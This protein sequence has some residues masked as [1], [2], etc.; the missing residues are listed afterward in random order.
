MII[1]VRKRISMPP[2]E[3]SAALQLLLLLLKSPDVPVTVL[4][5]CVVSI[6]D[7]VVLVLVMVVMY[8]L[9]VVTGKTICIDVFRVPGISIEHPST[10]MNFNSFELQSF[11]Y[12][13]VNFYNFPNIKFFSYCYNSHFSDAFVGF[14]NGMI[15]IIVRST[16][17]I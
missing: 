4:V 11:S 15:S 13:Q 9:H 6:V 10:Y 17:F 3:E 2:T 5:E 7:T 1:A 14:I 16:L 8:V 12:S